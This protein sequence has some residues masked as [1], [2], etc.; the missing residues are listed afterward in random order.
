MVLTSD[1]ESPL[2]TVPG[3]AKVLGEAGFGKAIADGYGEALDGLG[4]SDTVLLDALPGPSPTLGRERG[5]ELGALTL[6]SSSAAAA[7]AEDEVILDA[8]T[9][10]GSALRLIT[11][12]E[13]CL[14]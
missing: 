1:L 11:C 13:V 4:P 5:G 10:V 6:T 12:R 2:T 3:N 14:T 8:V 7:A 9:S